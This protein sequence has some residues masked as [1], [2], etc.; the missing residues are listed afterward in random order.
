MSAETNQCSFCL[1]KFSFFFVMALYDAILI[2]NCGS[3]FLTQT[4][5]SRL[6]DQHSG[7]I[8]AECKAR[9]IIYLH[10]LF[11]PSLMPFCA[12]ASEPVI[13]LLL[14]NIFCVF[15]IV[16]AAQSIW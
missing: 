3:Q 10:A 7:P 13:I 1:D 6:Y 12:D 9:L 14:Y 4:A 15:I 5:C 2:H 8:P 11:R 16:T